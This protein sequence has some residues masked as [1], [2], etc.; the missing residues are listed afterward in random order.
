MIALGFIE[1]AGLEGESKEGSF[2]VTLPGPTAP[3]PEWNYWCFRD[4][5]SV[6]DLD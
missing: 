3:P 6:K 2:E 5:A 1:A 4:K